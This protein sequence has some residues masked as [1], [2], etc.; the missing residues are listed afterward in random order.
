MV[1][2]ARRP[3]FYEGFEL[4]VQA[5]LHFDQ[6]DLT[7]AREVA[8]RGEVLGVLARTLLALGETAAARQAIDEARRL[9]PAPT[10]F[11]S[12]D[13]DVALVRALLECDEGRFA[14]CRT[15]AQEAS[16]LARGDFRPDDAAE[17]EG[18]LAVAWLKEGNLL[19]A[20]RAIARADQ[21]LQV[22]EDRLLRLTGGIAA[23]RVQ[24]ATKVA[25]N[26][27]SAQQRLETLIQEA[28]DLGAVALALDARL[29]LGEIDMIAGDRADGRARLAALERDA[30]AKGFVAVARRAAAASR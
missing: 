16:A 20:Q 1:V 15:A 14:D 29:A 19:E 10:S 28:S 27:S 17:A 9:P 4:P 2:I 22:T 21:R 24:A 11:R 12:A 3:G 18:A 6:G 23:A 26:V 25:A 8:A 5:R 30:L 7:A 13:I